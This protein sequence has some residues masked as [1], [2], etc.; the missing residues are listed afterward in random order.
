LLS[1]WVLLFHD[2]ARP[3]SAT[4]AV[5]AI[6]QLKFNYFHAHL[7][8]AEPSP[9]ALSHNWTKK[10]S[11]YLAGDLPVMKLK[12]SWLRTQTEAFF[13]DGIRRLTNRYT[14]CVVTEHAQGGLE[15]PQINRLTA[16]I[17]KHALKR[18]QSL[19]YFIL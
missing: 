19:F 17:Y 18:I 10:R 1:K 13:A 5:Q 16:T 4:P 7:T 8:Q 11:R 15:K 9:I 14:T 3:H 12:A 2:D 6:R